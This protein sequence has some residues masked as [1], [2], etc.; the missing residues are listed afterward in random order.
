PA[1]RRPRPRRR[2]GAARRGSAAR[3]AVRR[4]R[5]AAGQP[6]HSRVASAR[7]PP[8]TARRARRNRPKM[9]DNPSVRRCVHAGC[10]RTRR[11]TRRIAAATGTSTRNVAS[12]YLLTGQWVRGARRKL[13]L[14][15]YHLLRDAAKDFRERRD[16]FGNVRRKK[17]YESASARVLID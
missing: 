15:L 11:R 16:A 13:C 1:H 3:G 2:R 6:G 8:R 9:P 17:V 14:T 5:A 12:D 4:E 7:T 10:T